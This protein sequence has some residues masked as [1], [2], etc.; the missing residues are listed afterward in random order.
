VKVRD[1]S[2]TAALN[3][4]IGGINISEGCPPSNINDAIRE[5]MAEIATFAGAMNQYNL[6]TNTEWTFTS[7][8]NVS[9]PIG[10]T[11]SNAYC[12]DGWMKN[13]PV[14][15]YQEATT[16]KAGSLYSAKI[17]ATAAGGG[18]AWPTTSTSP[19]HLANMKGRTVAFGAWAYTN[20]LNSTR[21]FLW[22]GTDYTY[23][24]YHPGTSAWVWLEVT[25]VIPTGATEFL[26]GI[27]PGASA[28]A[29]MSQPTLVYSDGIG[30]GN[31]IPKGSDVPVP[32]PEQANNFLSG[33][34][35]WSEDMCVAIQ[36]WS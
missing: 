32:T 2:T 5:G 29:Y 18:M 23:S 7:L 33:K 31:Y 14:D 25:A 8:A 19:S 24:S 11:A 30:S 28:T 20:A 21:L 12:F 13:D 35:S 22:D 16:I 17:T 36:I 4:N 26:C 15:V 9:G 34:M 27:V 10:F 3:T 1:W 6:L